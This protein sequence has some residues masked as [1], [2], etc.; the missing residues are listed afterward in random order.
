MRVLLARAG[1]FGGLV[2]TREA[3]E[4]GADSL[5]GQRVTVGFDGP[6]V[7]SV[8]QTWMD[9]DELWADVS[10]DR[11]VLPHELTFRSVD[12]LSILRVKQ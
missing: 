12:S 3:L 2:F 1:N 5:V 8:Q 11:A 9:G 7:G 4:A 10:L 6:A